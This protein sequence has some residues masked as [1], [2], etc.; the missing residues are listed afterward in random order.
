MAEADEYSSFSR[1]ERRWFL[2]GVALLLAFLG[3]M[4][5]LT[6]EHRQIIPGPTK[7]STPKKILNSSLFQHLGVSKV[8][9]HHYR[10]VMTAQDFSYSPSTI[11]VPAGS[12]ISFVITSRDVI[13]GF[14]VP[15]A[16]V[17]LEVI[18]GRIGRV[19]HVFTRPGTYNFECN[20]YCGVGHPYM[21]GHLTVVPAKQFQLASASGGGQ[22]SGGATAANGKS[23][24][25][26]HCAACHQQS[27]SGLPG[28][29]PP[30]AGHLPNFVG[31]QQ[32]RQYLMEAVLFGLDGK[33]QV[34]GQTYNG[35]M[36]AWDSS[37]DNKQVAAVLNYALTAWGNKKALPKQFSKYTASEVAAVRKRQLKPS[38]VHQDRSQ[39]KLSH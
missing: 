21:R 28:T 29:F 18:P 33:I 5:W 14:Q 34:K 37:L 8:G 20:Q 35:H 31:T 3:I 9:D 30:L 4:W 25:D 13:H 1:Y 15:G 22:A 19:S 23:I 24:F 39:L 12:K 26:G 36:P 2:I 11:K 10:V 27:G 17:N 38:Q 7:A 6:M 32:G 16:L